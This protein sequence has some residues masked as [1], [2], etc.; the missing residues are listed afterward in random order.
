VIKATTIFIL[1]L[2]GSSYSQAQEQISPDTITISS[3]KLLL[4]ALLW[5]P[6]GDGPFPAIIFSHGA[7]ETNDQHDPVQQTSVLGEIFAKNGYVFLGPFRRGT[8]LSKD[9]GLNAADLMAKAFKEKG[10]EERNK[11]QMQQLQTDQLEDMISALSS[12][13]QVRNVDTNR[14]AVLG[15]SFGGSLAMLV[16]QSDRR[17]KAVVIFGAAGHSWNLS[18]QL[19][20]RL[21]TAAKNLNAP[22]MISH[23]QNDYSI[24]P[25]YALDSIMNLLHKPHVLKIYPNFGKSQNEGHNLI[26]LR[27]EIWKTDVITFLRKNLD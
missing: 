10:Q 13:R 25:G 6:T 8:G 24:N 4:K 11:V 21:F 23:A 3:G 27:P 2:C 15:H 7:Y 14:I 18:P 19:R 26:F 12:L 16:A 20:T 22:V 1:L 17:I 5:K 9:Q